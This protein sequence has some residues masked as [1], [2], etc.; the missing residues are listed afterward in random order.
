M[1]KPAPWLLDTNACI[2]L[3]RGRDAGLAH[4]VRNRPSGTVATCG[5]VR[6]ELMVGAEKSQDADRGRA[7]VHRLLLTMAY[8][9]L[10]ED[11]ANEYARIRAHLEAAGSRIGENDLWIAA[12]AVGHGAAIVTRNRREFERVP[13]LAMVSW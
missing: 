8:L 11:C 12:I 13:G 4:L 5:I 3:L 1:A 10:S 2:L 6:G 9:P 7:M